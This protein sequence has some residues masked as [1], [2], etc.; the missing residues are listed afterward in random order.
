MRGALGASVRWL[1]I[2]A[3]DTP[4]SYV[5]REPM[6]LFF[7]VFI[8]NVWLAWGLHTWHLIHLTSL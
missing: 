5:V 7:G 3:S 8:N 4:N 2:G 1:T 6:A